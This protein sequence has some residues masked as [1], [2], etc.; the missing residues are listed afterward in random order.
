MLDIM[1]GLCGIG[2]VTIGNVEMMK[3][4][5]S[6]LKD[7]TKQKIVTEGIYH[8]TTR[9]NAERIL[10]SGFMMPSK[11][12]VNN[13]FSKSIHGKGFADFVYMFAG[14]PDLYMLSK[15]LSHR[16]GEKNDGT[17]YAVRHTPDKY[18]I[19]NYTE[20]FQDGAITYEGKL[21][22]ANSNP[23]IVRFKLEKG[24][25]VE[26]PLDEKVE[27]PS[28]M[29]RTIRNGKLRATN[30]KSTYKE[31]FGAIKFS[32]NSKSKKKFKELKQQ[33]KRENK[34]LNQIN[35]E[36]SEKTFILKN[37]NKVKT[38][39]DKFVDGRILS[40]FTLVTEAGE[41][42]CI[43]LDQID[44]SSISEDKMIEFFDKNIDFDSDVPQYIGRP[45]VKEDIVTQ[46]IDTNFNSHFIQKQKTKKTTD[47]VYA[48]IMR[49]SK[50]KKQL[51]VLKN[52]YDTTSAKHRKQA[53]SFFE[54]LK[55][56]GK[57]FIEFIKSE[58]GSIQ[59]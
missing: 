45:R 27:K 7:K 20:R 22:I 47:P 16:L 37:G 4:F 39:K 34:L 58:D 50:S 9:E 13:H 38:G 57:D 29:K 40:E 24:E 46:E 52:I 59:L 44:V 23:E 53:L 54:N 31:I 33:R 51:S 56:V 2:I 18:E 25:L 1:T 55:S 21:D 12:V 42:K 41:D 19:E 10:E 43:Y 15:N 11:G 8:L 6:D 30:I 3:S 35:S 26:I 28:F 5:Q 14:K 49:E 32:V 17:F 48:R 36:K